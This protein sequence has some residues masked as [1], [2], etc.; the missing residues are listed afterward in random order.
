MSIFA[1]LHWGLGSLLL[2]AAPV[3]RLSIL[4][5]LL[6]VVD[7]IPL[8]VYACLQGRSRSI[9]VYLGI[10]QIVA[11]LTY[12]Y[13]HLFPDATGVS[14]Y[15]AAISLVSVIFSR[16]P[17]QTWGWSP[18]PW[19][20]S[21]AILPAAAVIATGFGI[22][23][24]GLLIV[25]SFYAWLALTLRQIRLSYL[26]LILGN[27]ALFKG[28]LAV[29]ADLP[30]LYVTSVVASLLYSVQVDPRL[31]Q[32]A[33]RNTRHWLRSLALGLLALVI[34]YETRSG[35]LA[36]LLAIAAGIGMILAGLGLR[37]RAALFVGTGLLG[38]A[39]L[40]QLGLFVATYPFSLW[41]I[42]IVLGILFL[43]IGARFETRRQQVSTWM[44]DW[45]V[46]FSRWD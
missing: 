43:W 46:D 9:W 4:G 12:G 35:F 24:P 1:H 10:G 6:W 44:Q 32:A 36:G 34:L 45:R 33:E 38:L 2:A 19:Q 40:R 7:L 21:A 31:S 17:W 25:G 18:Q 42:L 20:R 16:V 28:L 14:G 37:I 8:A 27:W 29:R 26:S 11:S 23:I 41:G 3:L 22:G 39:V 15:A 13:A 30:L 5:D